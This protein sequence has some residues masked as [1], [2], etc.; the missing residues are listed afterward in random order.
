MHYVSETTTEKV[1]SFTN[2]R[3]EVLKIGIGQVGK[4]T[5][6]CCFE[7]QFGYLFCNFEGRFWL[8]E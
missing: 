7:A 4:E 1:Y 6:F 3:L 5:C 2:S 8:T